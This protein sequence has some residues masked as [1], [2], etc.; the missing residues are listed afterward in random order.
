MA[1]TLVYYGWFDHGFKR[2]S[3]RQQ[4]YWRKDDDPE[5]EGLE[6]EFPPQGTRDFHFGFM[7]TWDKAFLFVKVNQ[8]VLPQPVLFVPGRHGVAAPGPSFPDLGPDAAAAILLDMIVANP[9]LRDALG[10]KLHALW[11]ETRAE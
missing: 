11:A 2:L 7:E 8:L 3:A 6:V 1:H 10:K 4:R 5:R 9:A